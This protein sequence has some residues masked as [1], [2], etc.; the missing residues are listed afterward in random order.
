MFLFTSFLPPI[1]ISPALPQCSSYGGFSHYRKLCRSLVAPMK[2]RTRFCVWARSRWSQHGIAW[3][4]KYQY[5]IRK[6]CRRCSWHENLNFSFSCSFL[7]LS[8][9]TLS[10]VRNWGIPSFFLTA[11]CLPLGINFVLRQTSMVH[12]VDQ[13]DSRVI[14]KF[15]QASVV[16][17]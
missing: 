2:V 11:F 13:C 9:V 16:V 14:R 15:F 10:L 7:P 5:L 1:M 6:N 12:N 17:T 8:V 3:F 4:K